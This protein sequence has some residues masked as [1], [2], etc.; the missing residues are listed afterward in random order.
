MD[1]LTT[2]KMIMTEYAESTGLSNAQKPPRRYLWTDAFGVCN[3]LGLYRQTG[4]E[5]WRHSALRLVDQ[6]HDVLGH[7]RGDDERSGWISGLSEGEGKRHPVIGG[8]RIGKKIN[9][10]TAREPYDDRAEWDRDGQYYHYLT[11]WMH[12]LNCVSRSTGDPI[13]N[14]WAI[15]LAKNVHAAFVYTLPSGLKRMYWKMSIDLTR[16][17]VASMGQ[18]DPLDG[19]ITYSRLRTTAWEHPETADPG[20]DSEIADMEALC[21]GQIWVT[22][23]P[24]GIGGLLGDAY[25]IL[26]LITKGDFARTDFLTDLL[27]SSLAGLDAFKRGHLLELPADYRLAFREL[28]MSIGLHAVERMEEWLRKRPDLFPANHPVYQQMKQLGHF[29]PFQKTIEKFWLDP[30]NTRSQTWTE[31][32][33]I[34]RVM[35]ATSLASDGYL[36][37]E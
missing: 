17:L 16:P 35:L 21:S 28:G 5:A 15:E 33:D 22:D 36:D 18:H 13:F 14:S 2:V 31:H 19:L 4:E 30:G 37:G 6:V 20:L 34:N 24:L 1:P 11:K 10:R 25:R 27:E 29:V 12:A 32:L 23:D 3:F 8:L 26:Q 9:E 7:H